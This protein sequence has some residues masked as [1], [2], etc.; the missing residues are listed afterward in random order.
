M[1]LVWKCSEQQIYENPKLSYKLLNQEILKT[2]NLEICRWSQRET[3][4]FDQLLMLSKKRANKRLIAMVDVYTNS[5]QINI[6][7]H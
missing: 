1:P 3:K 7:I 4:G 2:A 5:N 6:S